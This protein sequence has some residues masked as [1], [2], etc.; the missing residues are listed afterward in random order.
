M[1]IH[2]E[3]KAGHAGSEDAVS[4]GLL[5]QTDSFLFRGAGDAHEEAQN[6]GHSAERIHVIV[7][8]TE[9][10]VS[11]SHALVQSFGAEEMFATPDPEPGSIPTFSPHTAQ[12]CPA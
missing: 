12:A 1:Q 7:I 11:I 6:F 3:I 4:D 8:Q 9:T 2:G 5:E 10:Q